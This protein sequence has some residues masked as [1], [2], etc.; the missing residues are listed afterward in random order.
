MDFPDFDGLDS[1]SVRELVNALLARCMEPRYRNMWWSA[2]VFEGQTPTQMLEGG[3]Y[4]QLWLLAD[5]TCDPQER[6]VTDIEN[7]R[8]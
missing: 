1:A 6:D 8:D 4:R 5:A 2:E 3:R 7:M